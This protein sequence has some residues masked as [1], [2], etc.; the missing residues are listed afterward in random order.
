M[1]DTGHFGPHSPGKFTYTH[2]PA[3]DR[4]TQRTRQALHQALIGLILE[5]DYDEITV[6]DIA[7]AANVGRSTFYAH[8]V[9][10][11][12]LL[13]SGADHMRA[14]LIQEHRSDAA[15]DDPAERR[16]L[17]FSRFMTTHMQEQLKLYRALVRGRAGTIMMERLAAYLAD[18][19]RAE[20]KASTGG[21]PP[22][23]TVQFVVGAYMS[24]LTWWLDRGAREPAEELDRAFR[25]LAQGAL[26]AVL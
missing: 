18:I 16:A 15:P 21:P 19:V 11:D 20:L 12:D 8:F 6:A 5:R 26:K 25:A 22:E 4:R 3:V 9:D 2:D 17:G 23:V 10:K 13:R 7:E 24:V 14:I 1:T